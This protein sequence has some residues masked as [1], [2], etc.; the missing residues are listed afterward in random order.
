[1][2]SPTVYSLHTNYTDL[3]VQ[4]SLFHTKV[5]NTSIIEYINRYLHKYM[6]NMGYGIL[7]DIYIY[8]NTNAQKQI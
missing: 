7:L 8:T 3:K 6:G 4:V 2:N 1:M 5:E